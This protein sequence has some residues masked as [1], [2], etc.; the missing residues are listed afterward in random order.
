MYCSSADWMER[1]LYHRVEVC[2]PITNKRLAKRVIEEAL[3]FYLSDNQ[4]AWQLHSDGSYQRISAGKSTK[5]SAQ[6][7]LLNKLSFH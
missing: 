1:N 6:E 7:E 2:F 3:L 4:Q 5:F